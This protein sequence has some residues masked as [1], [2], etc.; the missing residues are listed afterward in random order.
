MI[1][2]AILFDIV[3]VLINLIPVAGQI[4][5]PLIITPIRW[6]TFG[7]WLALHGINYFFPKRKMV[8]PSQTSSVRGVLKV[9]KYFNWTII[10]DFIPLLD[11]LPWTSI[12]IWKLTKNSQ[13]D[14]LLEY[15]ERQEAW[16]I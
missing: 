16:S 2:V 14:D 5:N 10:L 15:N 9:A 3:Q 4:I 11:I 13:K 1:T 6:A 7:F 12:N 8:N